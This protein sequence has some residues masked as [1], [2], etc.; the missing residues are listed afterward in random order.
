MYILGIN[1]AFHES[2][3]CILKDGNLIAAVEEERF[4]RIK[5]AK[6]ALMTAPKEIP[7]LAI[8]YCLEELSKDEE[9]EIKL[10]DIDH[11]AYS[12]DPEARLAGNI[13]EFPGKTH[14]KTQ[15]QICEELIFYYFNKQIPRYL[16]EEVESYVPRRYKEK[17]KFPKSVKDCKFIFHFIPHHICHGASAYFVS[18]FDNAA[19]LTVDGIGETTTTWIGIGEGNKLQ[20]LYH[21]DYP[22]SLGFLYERITEFLGFQKNND[23]YKIT[24]LAAYGKPRFLNE[25]KK[26]IILEPEGRFS[27]KNYFT[28]FRMPI[29]ESRLSELFRVPPRSMSDDLEI[30]GIHADIAASL[31][32]T[33]ENTLL[34][35]ANHV[36]KITKKKNLCIAGGVALNCKAISRLINESLFED[37]WIQPA[38]HDAGT[39]L[40]AAYYIYN[41]ILGNKKRWIM[42]RATLGPKFSDEEILEELKRLKLSP[43]MHKNTSFHE[44]ISKKCAKLLIE[45]KIVG[46]FQGRMEFGPRALG[47]R[48]ILV[49]PRDNK[50]KRLLNQIK[51]REDFRPFAPSVL[52]DE[53]ICNEWFEKYIKSPFMLI[54]FKVNENKRKLIPAAIHVDGTSRIQT[55]SK[56]I[57]PLYYSVIE[58]FFKLTGV[59][60]IVN[61]SFNVRGK[62]IVA[63]I[64]DAIRCFYSSGLDYL[65]LG[66]YLIN[67][68]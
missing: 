35:I 21:I 62:P 66:N 61:T 59:P 1:S 64:E 63:N 54:A 36:N 9:K 28:Q 30:N 39:G 24:G 22:N 29:Q 46:W 34:H 31:Q 2:S 4:N 44:D 26:L 5:H 55:V 15:D 65:I 38:A 43:E 25:F 16:T 14:Q 3:A 32:L 27:I 53:D 50:L 42:E 18:P 20:E 6:K 17:M 52:E 56:E 48:S 8:N 41:H 40:G 57:Q 37:V 60:M 68:E 58:E 45:G 67:K 12:F 19:I 47:N 10:N 33:L 49:D 23:E 13:T 51:G 11:I 7:Y